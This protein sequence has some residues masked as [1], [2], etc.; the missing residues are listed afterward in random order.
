MTALSRGLPTY[1]SSRI[2][3]RSHAVVGHNSE[4]TRLYL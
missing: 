2:Q 1:R 4:F 3:P